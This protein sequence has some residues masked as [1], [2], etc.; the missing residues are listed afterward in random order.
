MNSPRALA[1]TSRNNEMKQN[2]RDS[3]NETPRILS[4][5]M[6]NCLSIKNSVDLLSSF[7]V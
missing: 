5:G 7:A 6:S 4:L 3:S 1:E 2:T